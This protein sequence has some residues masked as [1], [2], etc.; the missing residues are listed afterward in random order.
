MFQIFAACDTGTPQNT[1]GSEAC[2]IIDLAHS[3]I[4]RLPPS[5]I[6]FRLGEWGIVMLC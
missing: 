1:R 2:C 5:A 3:T 4:V 6:L